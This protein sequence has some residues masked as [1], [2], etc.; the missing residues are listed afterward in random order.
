MR[1]SLMNRIAVLAAIFVTVACGNGG[2]NNTAEQNTG[3]KFAPQE[4]T[5]S[6][7]AEQRETLLNEVVDRQPV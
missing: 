4:H 7:T 1:Q 2:N 5:S 3:T 6:M